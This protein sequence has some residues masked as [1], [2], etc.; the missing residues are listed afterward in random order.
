MS[1]GVIDVDVSAEGGAVSAQLGLQQLPT[2]VIYQ[3]GKEVARL[4]S[5]PDRRKLAE[6][7]AH[8]VAAAAAATTKQQQ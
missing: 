5:S 1:F 7:L 2:Y 3:N 6:V 8:H 4:S